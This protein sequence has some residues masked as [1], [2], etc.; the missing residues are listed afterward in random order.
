MNSFTLKLGKQSD[1]DLRAVLAI[2]A[3][4]EGDY[5]RLA[6][7]WREGGAAPQDYK[8]RII[9]AN[10]APTLTRLT[11]DEIKLRVPHC[12]EVQP[13]RLVPMAAVRLV[14]PVTD[15]QRTQMTTVYPEQAEAIA[16][17]ETRFEYGVPDAAGDP[18]I[19]HYPVS[20]KAMREARA[21]LI[22]IGGERYI[23]AAN[24]T[25]PEKIRKLTED[26][27]SKLREAYSLA[28]NQGVQIPTIHGPLIGTVPAHSIRQRAEGTPVKK[29]DEPRSQPG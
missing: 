17:K 8:A 13:G 23:F 3:L 27:L 29:K 21:N 5:K 19:K 18:V 10:R 11:L 9:F 2:E 4:E 22:N 25:D 20:I 6:E 1:I 14:R 15:E 26:E 16:A 28:D 24:I 12:I 7:S